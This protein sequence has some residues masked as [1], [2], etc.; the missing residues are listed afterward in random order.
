M[1]EWKKRKT[2]SQLDYY[3]S[4]SNRFNKWITI[5]TVAHVEQVFRNHFK[6]VSML[7]KLTRDFKMPKVFRNLIFKCFHVLLLLTLS[8]DLIFLP[9]LPW[10]CHVFLGRVHSNCASNIRDFNCVGTLFLK[11]QFEALRI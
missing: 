10:F 4:F 1:Q 6:K 2:C 7:V 5:K 3:E 8:F 11:W 9:I